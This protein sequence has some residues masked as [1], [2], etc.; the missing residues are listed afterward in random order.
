MTGNSRTCLVGFKSDQER[1]QTVKS[2]LAV[3]FA[4]G[5]IT[6]GGHGSAPETELNCKDKQL[7]TYQAIVPCGILVVK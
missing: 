2:F 1:I 6:V 5:N 7:L 4:I 3:L